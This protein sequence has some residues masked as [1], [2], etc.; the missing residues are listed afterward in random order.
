MKKGALREEVRSRYG[1]KGFT[2]KGDIKMSVLRE[3]KKMSSIPMGVSFV[4]FATIGWLPIWLPVVYGVFVL[5]VMLMPVTRG[6][7]V[8]V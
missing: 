2:K 6:E 5:M 1:N 4:F 8:G 3:L 7:S